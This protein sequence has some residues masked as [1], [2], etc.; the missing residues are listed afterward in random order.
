MRRQSSQAETP[1]RIL[2]TVQIKA[3]ARVGIV[4]GGRCRERY[5]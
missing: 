3:K 4:S 5:Q 1:R 2:A